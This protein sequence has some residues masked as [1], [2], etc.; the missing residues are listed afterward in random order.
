MGNN[1]PAKIFSF[2]A[3]TLPREYGGE[4]LVSGD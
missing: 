4:M 1:S 2:G 3:A